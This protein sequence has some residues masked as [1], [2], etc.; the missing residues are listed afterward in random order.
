MSVP[1]VDTGFFWLS[2][3]PCR[4]GRVGTLLAMI[5]IGPRR[6]LHCPPFPLLSVLESGEKRHAPVRQ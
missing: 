6:S 3:T 1:Q 5:Y 2:V 4:V